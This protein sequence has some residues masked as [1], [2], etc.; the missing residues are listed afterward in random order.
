MWASSVHYHHITVVFDLSEVVNSFRSCDEYICLNIYIWYCTSISRKIID[1][2]KFELVQYQSRIY[3]ETWSPLLLQNSYHISV[4]FELIF[5]FIG[6][7]V[8]AS[9]EQIALFKIF[10]DT[11]WNSHTARTTRPVPLGFLINKF[12]L[13]DGAGLWPIK[14]SQACLTS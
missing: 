6:D 8:K 7:V 12:P 11:L 10:R 13:W 14:A 5:C 3:P 4:C 2:F 1:G 9:F